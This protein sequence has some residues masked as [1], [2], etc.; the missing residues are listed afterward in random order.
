MLAGMPEVDGPRLGREALQE[1]PVVGGSVG[2]RDDGDIGARATD[3]RNLTCELGFQRALA[4]LRHT[5]EIEGLEPFALGVVEGDRAAGGFAA[6][7]PRR[8][9]PRRR[10]A[11]P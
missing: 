6:S 10:A 2:K 3:M 8:A 11:P 5:G 9:R 1:G 4:A 7:R